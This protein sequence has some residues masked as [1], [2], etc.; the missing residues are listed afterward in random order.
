MIITKKYAGDKTIKG[1]YAPIDVTGVSK[2]SI[3]NDALVC[4]IITFDY[5]REG[6]PPPGQDHDYRPQLL[7]LGSNSFKY[8]GKKRM[9][10]RIT[11]VNLHYLTQGHA[12]ALI[13]KTK[14]FF[15]YRMSSPKFITDALMKN[16]TNSTYY[17]QYL[18]KNITRFYSLYTLDTL[19][20]VQDELAAEGSKIDYQVEQN[21][22]I[23]V[24]T[25]KN[26]IKPGADSNLLQDLGF[27][28]PDLYK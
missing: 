25:R 8:A 2:T 11:G 23:K 5:N 9:T 28:E 20:N 1:N 15:Q 7:I 3:L 26:E 4:D 17:R 12:D 14:N 19:E 24:R 21:A 18:I 10:D 13:N 27:H 6:T 16:K 22:R